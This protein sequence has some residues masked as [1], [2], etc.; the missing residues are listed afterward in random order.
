MA[1]RWIGFDFDGTLA[2]HVRP[3]DP[4]RAGPPTPL[5]D[6]LKKYLAMGLA[7]RI[8]TARVAREDDELGT[9]R[10]IEIGRETIRN[11]C[12]QYVGR[13]LPITNEKDNDMLVLFDDR[14]RQV[15]SDTGQL[16]PVIPPG[17]DYAESG[18]E[19]SGY[20]E[21]GPYHCIDCRHY[22]DGACYHPLVMIDP[23][24]QTRRRENGSIE[25]N[26]YRGCCRVVNQ[27]DPADATI[28]ETLTYL[29]RSERQ[30]IS[31]YE[32]SLRVLPAEMHEAIRHI[33][34][35]ER[36]HDQILIDLKGA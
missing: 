22:R 15:I 23:E 12:L 18:T 7:V 36:H 11:W 5:L 31:D 28:P 30:A 26:P 6:L 25:I 1:Q 8:V 3:F 34:D 29:I 24:L 27:P 32:D 9:I 21:F 14:A 17:V 4:A 10:R 35:E 16:F 13:E 20:Q 33:Q 2:K 19:I